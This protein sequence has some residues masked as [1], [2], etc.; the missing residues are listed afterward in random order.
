[1]LT[2]GFSDLA[3]QNISAGQLLC[4]GLFSTDCLSHWLSSVALSHALVGNTNNKELLLRVHLAIA[5]DAAPVSLL[6]QAFNI[7]QQVLHLENLLFSTYLLHFKIFQGGKL[8]TRLGVLTL[9]STWLAD[10]PNSVAQ[11][12]KLPNAIAFLTALVKGYL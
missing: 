1:M 10:C 4:G 5:K 12:L 9:L 8:Q 11:F 3:M 2:V 6:Q 7:L